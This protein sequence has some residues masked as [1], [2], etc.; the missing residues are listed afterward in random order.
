MQDEENDIL[1]KYQDLE[2]PRLNARENMLL[3]SA[4]ENKSVN[5]N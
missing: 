3:I 1:S 4:D 2:I 5:P